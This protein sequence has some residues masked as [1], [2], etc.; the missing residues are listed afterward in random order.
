MSDT[1]YSWGQAPDNLKTRAQ[2]AALGLWPG[3]PEV[4]RIVWSKGRQQRFAA[5]YEEAT[6]IP[7]K[8]ATPAQLAGLEKA[9]RQ[10]EKC[11][12]CGYDLGRVPGR[13][14]IPKYDCPQCFSQQRQ[15]DR[16][17]ATQIAQAALANPRTVI[18]DTETTDLDGYI[19]Q[20]AVLSVDETVLF[21]SLVNPL[22]PI[23]PDA[24]AIHGLTTELLADA[25]TFAALETQLQELLAGRPVWTYNA[26]FDADILTGDVCRLHP[27]SWP[28]LWP[29]ELN[30]NCAM[31]LY[32]QW[33]GEWSAYQQDYRWQRLPGGDHTALGDCRA[34]LALFKEMAADG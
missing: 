15:V 19:V 26:E 32:A 13:L 22:T 4:A 14:F 24:Q 8:P 23:A 1:I 21:D 31:L 20:I 16:A 33:V 12:V 5:L 18:L 34:T 3:G 17:E 30:W 25:P 28:N 6:A 27:R 10:K 2:L 29:R 9:R 11:P 7:K